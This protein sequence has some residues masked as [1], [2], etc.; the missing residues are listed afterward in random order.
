ML[1]KIS[2]TAHHT[3]TTEID[4]GV[5]GMLDNYQQQR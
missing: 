1:D 2:A 3:E 4:W 5:V